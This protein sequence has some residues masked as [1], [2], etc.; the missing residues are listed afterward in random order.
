MNDETNDA[1]PKTTAAEPAPAP[2]PALPIEKRVNLRRFVL[3]RT[4]DESGT[5]GTGI[6]AE[7]VEFTD[8]SVALRWRSIINSTVVYDN[9]KAVDLIHGHGGKTQ[10]AFVE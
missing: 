3:L 4:E 10:V 5:S 1:Q 2:A 8:G 9:L 7:G 6:V